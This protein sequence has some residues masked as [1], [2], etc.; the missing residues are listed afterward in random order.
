MHPLM[1]YMRGRVGDIQNRLG[2]S[3]WAC[4]KITTCPRLTPS[5]KYPLPGLLNLFI[6][7]IKTI[8]DNIPIIS[9]FMVSPPYIKKFR[10]VSR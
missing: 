10:Q 6:W 7:R 9:S 2:K 1:G 8:R 3:S 5:H 4:R